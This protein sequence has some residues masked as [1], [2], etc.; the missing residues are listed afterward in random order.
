MKRQ[1]NHRGIAVL[2]ALAAFVFACTGCGGGGGEQTAFSVGGILSGLGTGKSVTLQNVGSDDLELSENGR[3]EFPTKL[4]DGSPYHVTVSVQ[5]EGQTCTVRN[6]SGTVSGADVTDVEVT[7]VDEGTDTYTVGGTLSGLGAGKSVTLQNNGGDDLTLTQDGSFTFP[8]PLQDGTGYSVTVSVQPVGQVCQVANNSGTVNGANVTNVEVICTD[9]GTDT[10]TVGG[11]L[12][13][14]GTGKTVTLQNNGGDDL[15]LDANGP[16]AFSTALPALTPYNVTVAV[17]PDG[18]DCQVTNG[19]G[20]ITDHDVVD[21]NVNCVDSAV[22]Y[23]VGVVL[24]GLGQGKSVTVQNNGGDDMTLNANGQYDFPTPLSP[25]MTFNVTVSVQPQG[26]VCQ[27]TADGSGTITTHDVYASVTCQDIQST[28]SIGGTLSGLAPGKAVTLQNNGGD[29]LTLNA[30]GPFQFATNL[31]DGNDY[32]VTV[33]AQP[34][35]QTCLVRNGMGTVA[36]ADVTDIEVQCLSPGSLDPAF[37]NNGVFLHHGA[38]G[39]NGN[40]RAY[41][42]VADRYDR[43]LLTGYSTNAN[44]DADMVV[45]RLTPAGALDATFGSGGFVVHGNAAG[46]DGNDVGRGIAVTEKWGYSI[47]VSGDSVNS[48]G[49]K[50]VVIWVLDESGAFGTFSNGKGW[51]AVDSIAGGGGNDWGQDIVLSAQVPPWI[52]GS[53]AN[54]GGNLDMFTMNIAGGD[55]QAPLVSQDPAGGAGN[56]QAL[57]ATLDIP[58]RVVWSTGYGSNASGNEDAIVWK[59]R[60]IGFHLSVKLVID[61]GAGGNR[62]RGQGIAL[63]PQKKIYVTGF[64]TNASG[65]FDMVLWRLVDTGD[66]LDTTFGSNGVVVA[67]GSAGGSGNDSGQ[68]VVVDSQGRAVVAGYSTNANGDKDVAVWRFLQDG[69]PDPSFGTNGVLVFDGIA[70]GTGDDLAYGVA[71]DSQ[72]R[73]LVTGSSVDASGNHEMFVLAIVP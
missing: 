66:A 33:S 49:N 4:S 58:N 46:G 44:G 30:N 56:D 6:G 7:C 23:K 24:S 34:S 42:I 32:L 26:Q 2:G 27:V 67:G 25:G 37:G 72:E 1:R 62:Q 60:I 59:L 52:V 3:F 61:T 28:F 8:T 50:D 41:D 57:A 70:G 11:S 12:G 55:A 47:E 38:A 73:I 10:Y 16:F 29:D 17:Q 19:S 13:G 9:Q 68:A 15:T 51:L 53:S 36:G 71:L 54:A 5:P 18:Q 48:S 45:W 20:T 40:D 39:G 22:Q 31:L 43:P 64:S 65:D 21:V 63:G 14:L 35:G 69:T